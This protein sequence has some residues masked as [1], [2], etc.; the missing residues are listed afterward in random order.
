V[1]VRIDDG[2]SARDD[3]GDGDGNGGGGGGTFS[4]SL[5]FIF[6]FSK[7]V[8]NSFILS[9]RLYELSKSKLEIQIEH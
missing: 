7:S 8:F 4:T 5:D 2:C 3:A 1:F 9:S 6:N